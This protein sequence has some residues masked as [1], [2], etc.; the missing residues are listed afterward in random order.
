MRVAADFGI[1]SK[2]VTIHEDNQAAIAMSKNFMVKDRSKHI[3][4][5]HYFIREQVADG[6]I[7]V[8]HIPT[9]DQL[10]DIFTKA[11]VKIIFERLRERLGMAD[12]PL[13]E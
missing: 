3:A 8:I 11:L 1:D 5:R 9:E 2:P 4:T 12:F 6:T 10:A 13:E 7:S